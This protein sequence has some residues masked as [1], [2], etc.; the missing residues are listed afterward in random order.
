MDGQGVSLIIGALGGGLVSFVGTWFT[1]RRHQQKLN[2]N[3]I[4]DNYQTLYLELRKEISRL[5][6]SH[7]LERKQWSEKIEVLSEKIDSQTTL[8]HSKDIEII[9]LKAKVSVMEA[10]LKSY[11]YRSK[12]GPAAAKA[13]K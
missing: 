6:E 5:Q 7:D 10:Q 2:S 11:E 8:I 3:L 9:E 12:D 1:Q 13:R 4:Q